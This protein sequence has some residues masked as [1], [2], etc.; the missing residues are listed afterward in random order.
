M[1][2]NDEISG[3]IDPELAALFDIPSTAGSGESPGFTELFSDET[4][5]G[6][7]GTAAADEEAKEQ[8]PRESFKTVDIFEETEKPFFSNPQYYS[9]LLSSG[10]EEAKNLHTLLTGFMKTE[11]PKERTQ[12]RERMTVSFWNFAREVI[13]DTS[14]GFSTE[15]MLLFRFGVLHPGLLSPEQKT[16]LS[17]TVLEN[18]WKEPVHYIDE[19]LRSIAAGTVNLSATDETKT[20]KRSEEDKIS[21]QLEKEKGRLEFQVNRI[22]TLNF[23]MERQEQNLREQVNIL[24]SHGDKFGYEGLKEGYST[25]QRSSFTSIQGILKELQQIDKELERSFRELEE[26]QAAVGSLESKADGTTSTAGVDEK[27]MEKE[28]QTVKQMHKMCVGRQG[29]HIPVL[30]KQYFRPNLK[31]IGTRENVLA[32]LADVEKIDPGVFV[33]TFKRET[34]RIVP[35]VLLVP[36]Y[37]DR[38]ICWEPFEKFNRATSRGRIAVPMFSKEIKTAV[39]N[40]CADL[41]WQVAKERAQHYWMEEGLTGRYYQWFSGTKQRGDLKDFFIQDYY[42]WITKESEGIQKLDRDVREVFWRYVPF[43]QDLKENLK[44]RGFIYNELYKKDQNRAM[45]D[46]Y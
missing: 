23:D 43:P 45:S 6:R 27:A 7:E 12:L 14:S 3:D 39:I 11:D 15:K 22:K 35:H 4:P 44:N 36:C 21:G 13:A 46:G 17:K 41:R 9:V 30:M 24:A 2:E 34:T 10:G 25:E 20:V 42:L 26:A 19:W 29:N 8:V 40:A 18:I 31:D 38:G 28:F 5:A 1:A 33:R 32:L 16:L 37:G